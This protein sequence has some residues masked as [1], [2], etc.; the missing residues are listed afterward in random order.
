MP[1]HMVTPGT[2]YSL[3]NLQETTKATFPVSIVKPK[4]VFG[5]E[6]E[7]VL[8]ICAKTHLVILCRFRGD[9]S[10]MTFK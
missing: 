6:L 5:N 1:T 4:S 7:H 3:N 8:K 2:V 10:Q 9:I